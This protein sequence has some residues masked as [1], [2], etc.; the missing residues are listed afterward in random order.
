MRLRWR[1]FLSWL[2][3][4]LCFA[5]V[6]LALAPLALILFYVVKQGAGSLSVSFFTRMPAPVGEVGGGMLNGIVGSLMVISLGALF[7]VPVG[8]IAGIY[9]SEFR[10]TRLA[11][12]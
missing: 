3:T 2:V 7:A 1:K 12:A 4:C 8:V 9:A 10:G 5:A 6:L 11:G